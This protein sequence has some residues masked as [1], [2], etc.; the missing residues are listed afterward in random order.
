V[1]KILGIAPD[2]G[3]AYGYMGE[4]LYSKSKYGEAFEA[5]RKSLRLDQG[6]A[7]VYFLLGKVFERLDRLADAVL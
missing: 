7:R 1:K 3:F 4:I 5:L 6:N 2:S